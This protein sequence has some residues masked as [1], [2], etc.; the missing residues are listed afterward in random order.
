[1]K[2]MEHHSEPDFSLFTVGEA[3]GCTIHPDVVC[4]SHNTS[5]TRE[6]STPGL[7]MGFGAWWVDALQ[8]AC[9]AQDLGPGVTTVHTYIHAY[10]VHVQYIRA[11]REML[12]SATYPPP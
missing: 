10:S 7:G 12:A 4:P 11:Y 1:M 5:Y 9:S 3:P 2:S 8:L 6:R